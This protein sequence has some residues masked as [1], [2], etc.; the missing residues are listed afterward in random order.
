MKAF[1]KTTSSAAQGVHEG[2]FDVEVLDA[3]CDAKV[4]LADEEILAIVAIRREREAFQIIEEGLLAG[5]YQAAFRDDVPDTVRDNGP[6]SLEHFK[7]RKLTTDE[8][9]RRVLPNT[10]LDEPASASR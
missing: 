1:T 4:A 9:L 6:V 8:R 7:F 2:T 10:G 5:E 3:I